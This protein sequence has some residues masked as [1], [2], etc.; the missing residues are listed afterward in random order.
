MNWTNCFQ[1]NGDFIQGQ[2]ISYPDSDWQV[3]NWLTVTAINKPVEWSYLE[4]INSARAA[5]CTHRQLFQFA[6]SNLRTKT[7]LKTQVRR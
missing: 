1:S 2:L 5:K 7:Q 4:I 3:I 6:K